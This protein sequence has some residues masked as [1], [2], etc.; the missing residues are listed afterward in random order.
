MKKAAKIT[1]TTSLLAVILATS[2]LVGCQSLSGDEGYDLLQ[3]AIDNT[4]HDDNAHIFYWKESIST[5]RP[6]S[7]T[8]LV[9]TTTVNV[10]C[11]IDRDYNFVKEGD[12]EYDYED[13]KARVTKSYDGK[14]VY[15]LYCGYAADGNSYQ[16]VRG[17]LDGQTA[18]TA[19]DSYSFTDR[20]A[21]EYVMSND[22][23]PYTLAE[24]LKELKS[25]KREDLLVEEYEN[26]GVEKKGNVTTIT[27]K[28]SEDYLRAYEEANGAKSVLEGKYVTIEMA[29][30]R[31]SAI[32]VYQHD[33][34][35]GESNTQGILALEYES[36]KF[37]VVY[38]G[39]KFTVPSKQKE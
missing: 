2:L 37:E 20:V 28:L 7:I 36:Y 30:D 22:F 18:L 4:L 31:I 38:T 3:K 17:A 25:L 35:A 8:N 13:L 34:N 15:E 23:K 19:N 32:I 5:P 24:K 33:P 16:A 11:T 6:N 12:G 9:E 1:L 26:G 39:P 14:Q 10:L 27:C 29:Y 21:E